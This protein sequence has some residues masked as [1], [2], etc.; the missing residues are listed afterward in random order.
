LCNSQD[1]CLFRPG[2]HFICKIFKMSIQIFAFFLSLKF[3]PASSSLLSP[4]K[5]KKK[6]KILD[7]IWKNEI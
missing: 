1:A 3:Q 4:Q 7:I 6:E 2:G 5:I